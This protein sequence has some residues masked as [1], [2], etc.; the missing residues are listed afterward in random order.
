LK[1]STYWIF[2][3]IICLGVLSIASVLPHA[4]Y[5]RYQALTV[6]SY[7][8]AT[9]IYER[10]TYDK[11]PIDI[12]F[13]GT[14]HTLNAV[15]SVTVENSI[16]NKNNSFKHVVNFAI[17]HFGRDM[18]KLIIKLLIEKKAPEVI[19]IEIR[20]SEERD[21]HPAT[22]YLADASELLN[23]PLL[24]NLRYFGNLMRLPLRQSSLFLKTSFP[25]F[26]GANA[27]FKADNYAGTHLNFTTEFTNGK[28][29]DNV[30]NKSDLEKYSEQWN[31]ENA[32][33]LNRDNEFKNFI[34]FNANWLNLKSAIE[35]AKSN[36][37][38]V[39]FTYL[40]NYGASP[41]PID[42]LVYEN[43]APILYVK[44]D[45]VLHDP[46]HW[47]DLGHL[48]GTGA[49]AYSNEISKILTEELSL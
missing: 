15:D 2:A 37:I 44:D 6:G 34:Y 49:I 22:H 48:N 43:I 26:F 35:L 19:L 1:K 17:P 4:T 16:N 45:S 12:A 33:K 9:W 46:K 40:P 20:E 11:T 27:N 24:V 18:H 47:Y 23:A 29:R 21:Q 32:F 31:Q 28:I 5:L 41:K 10:A 39:Y 14:S 38:K 7:S 8:K 3:T 30:H 36:G 13:I 25:E 42:A